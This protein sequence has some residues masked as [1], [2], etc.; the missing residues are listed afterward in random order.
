MVK[1][2]L[3][4]LLLSLALVLGVVYFLRRVW[5]YRDPVRVPPGLPQAI[6]SPADGTVVYVR[7][8]GEGRVIAEKLGERISVDEICR[9]GDTG[10]G[11]GWIVGIFMSPLDV[12]FN[13]SPVA[14]RVES[15]VHTPA[16]V[17]LP[18]LDLWEYVQLTYLRR[19]VDL[20][21]YRYRLINERNTIFLQGEG[22]RIAVVEIADKFVN[23]IRCYVQ[24]GEWLTAGQKLSFIER[25]S[26]VDLI[27]FQPTLKIL[28]RPGQRVIGA[29]T[30]IAEYP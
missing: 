10:A 25:G 20:F 27:I 3:A 29:R 30:V 28:V 19:A 13:Y 14:G 1:V 12:H 26:Q 15:V 21:S 18:M 7:P 11:E 9:A 2:S 6:L 4:I 16:R 24:P 17:N 8:F 22:P 23:K 5:F